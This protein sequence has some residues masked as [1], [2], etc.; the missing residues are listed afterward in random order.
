[1]AGGDLDR[2]VPDIGTPAAAAGASARRSTRTAATGAHDATPRRRGSHRTIPVI[3][4][5]EIT[6]EP[7]PRRHGRRLQGPPDPAQPP[8]CAR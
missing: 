8:L 2:P 3:P 5:Y 4:G 7:E 6:G 1:M